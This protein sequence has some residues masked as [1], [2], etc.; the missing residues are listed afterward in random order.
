MSFDHLQQILGTNKKNRTFSVHKHSLTG[1]LHVYYG[2]DLFDVV[3]DDRED[4][5]FKIMV[6]HLRN[7]GANLTELQKA[8]GVDPR[9]VNLWSDA[10]KSGD[11]DRLAKALAGQKGG[12]KLT[13]QI[14][15]YI[16][17]RFPVLYT[18]NHYTYSRIIRDEVEQIFKTTLCSETLRPLFN[19]LKD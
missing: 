9:A 7:V 5:R 4:T 11:A 13:P 17:V 16:R 6:A 1:N 18:D 14:V 12:R 10:L 15:Q 8:F 19:E 2:L 3:P